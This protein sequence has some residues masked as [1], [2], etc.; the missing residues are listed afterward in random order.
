MQSSAT[1]AAVSPQST[2][3]R[4]E[5]CLIRGE[6]RNSPPHCFGQSLFPGRNGQSAL[7]RRAPL[8]K[9]KSLGSLF[10]SAF[11]TYENLAG[12]PA[13]PG[14]RNGGRST[15]SGSASATVVAPSRPG[16]GSRTRLIRWTQVRTPLRGFFDGLRHGFDLPAQLAASA[17]RS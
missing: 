5:I 17:I 10:Q 16:H 14:R 8:R 9:R 12:Q 4:L 13:F 7:R 1:M 11:R 15:S 3:S 2:P 6:E